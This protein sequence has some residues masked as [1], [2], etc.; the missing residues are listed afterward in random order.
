[1]STQVTFLEPS[2]NVSLSKF[3][4]WQI[5]FRISEDQ[6]HSKWRLTILKAFVWFIIVNFLPWKGMQKDDPLQSTKSTVQ[7]SV[8]SRLLVDDCSHCVWKF[9]FFYV[10]QCCLFIYYSII[11]VFKIFFL[12][13]C[14]FLIFIP[15]LTIKIEKSLDGVLGIRTQDRSTVGAVETTELWLLPL[16]LKLF[17]DKC[18]RT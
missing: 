8:D 16:N 1:M 15:I 17:R 7:L 3:D 11:F 5:F 10:K 9:F 18:E 2:D 6:C 13:F 12:Y 4:F 14:P